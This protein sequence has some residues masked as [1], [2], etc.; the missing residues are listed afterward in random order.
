MCFRVWFKTKSDLRVVQWNALVNRW[1]EDAIERN[2]LQSGGGHRKTGL[3]DTWNEWDCVVEP[4][5]D[6]DLTEKKRACVIAWLEDEAEIL[7]YRVG[8]P[9][10]C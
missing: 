9:V 1:I 7:A 5:P 6:C 4:Q 8:P 3:S 2:G 10:D